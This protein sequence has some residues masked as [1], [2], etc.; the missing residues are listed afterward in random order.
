MAVIELMKTG[1]GWNEG[2]VGGL[3]DWRLLLLL[4]TLLTNDDRGL[5]KLC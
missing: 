2:L 4:A 3:T 1:L 5:Q